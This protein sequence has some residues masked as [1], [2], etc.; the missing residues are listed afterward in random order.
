MTKV[1]LSS[2]IKKYSILP[3]N[4]NRSS[5]AIIEISTCAKCNLA[6]EMK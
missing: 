3:W 5:E 2:E 4:G 6:A 1:S